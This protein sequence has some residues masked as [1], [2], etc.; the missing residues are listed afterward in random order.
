MVVTARAMDMTVFGFFFNGVT[1]IGYFN[2]KRQLLARQR[3][4]AV[5]IYVKAANLKHSNLHLPIVGVEA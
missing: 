4:V 5:N 3:V 2:V 1:N